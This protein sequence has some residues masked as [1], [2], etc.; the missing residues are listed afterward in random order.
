MRIIFLL[1][2]VT[3]FGGIE[4]M[5]TDKAN[6][7]A[8]HGHD[9]LF[10]TYE[11]G[12]HK[13]FFPLNGEACHEDLECRYFTVYQKSALTR[14]FRKLLM[15]YRFRKKLRDKIDS[16][17]PDVMVISCSIS[18][19]RAIAIS[20]NRLVPVV[21]ENHGT[22]I[23]DTK[24]NSSRLQHWW[25]LWVHRCIKKCS[26]IIS[27]TEGDAA[28]WRRF[29]DKVCVIPNPLTFYNPEP[30][31]QETTRIIC[32]GRL[33]SAKRFDRVVDAFSMIAEKYPEWH[34]DIF[35]EGELEGQLQ[36]R[37]SRSHVSGRVRINRPTPNIYAEY[38]RSSFFVLTSDMESFGLVMIEAMSCGIPVVSVNCPFGPSEIIEDGVTG[39]L[40]EMTVESLSEKM[41]WMITHKEERLRMGRQAHKAAARYEKD[42]VM[43]QWET[44]YLSVRRLP[45]TFSDT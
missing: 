27:L 43:K 23:E 11:Q 15:K 30:V 1:R 9:V 41:E 33:V 28:C 21:Y 10:L 24:V 32:V 16:F 36:E 18:E 19:F 31:L 38:Q 2:S 44:A 22:F 13:L 40:S 39:L 26:L 25:Q 4:R 14:P 3:L 5:F 37:I 8:S 17:R 20:M 34:V 12:Q 29:S 42:N 6:W 35:G 45:R 7:L